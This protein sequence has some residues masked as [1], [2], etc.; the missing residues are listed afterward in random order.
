MDADVN[1]AINVDRMG[2][3]RARYLENK[4]LISV[5]A[6]SKGISTVVPTPELPEST[7]KAAATKGTTIALVGVSARVLL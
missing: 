3:K 7:E 6:P 2:Q 1:A 4:K 5:L